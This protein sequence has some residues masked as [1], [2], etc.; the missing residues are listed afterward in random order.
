M[1]QED[2]FIEVRTNL[3]NRPIFK[4][5]IPVISKRLPLLFDTYSM[6]IMGQHS[7]LQFSEYEDMEAEEYFA[8]VIYGAYLS[9]KLKKNRRPKISIEDAV[10]W[11]KGI[12]L[13]DRTAIFETI[14]VSKSIGSTL[15]SYQKAR[16]PEGE[17][18]R[19]KKGDGSG[20][21]N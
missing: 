5:A 20:Q 16:N 3:P 2:G 4:W 14:K 17:D 10:K 13:E 6:V 9:Y 7:G 1:T 19:S 8:W 21:K 12:L 15:E 18:G 11:A